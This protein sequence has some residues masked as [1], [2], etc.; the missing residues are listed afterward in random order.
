MRIMWRRSD[1]FSPSSQVPREWKVVKLWLRRMS[2][3]HE[4]MAPFPGGLER[5][6]NPGCAPLP[7]SPNW[8]VRLHGWIAFQSNVKLHAQRQQRPTWPQRGV[9]AQLGVCCHS[10]GECQCLHLPLLDRWRPQVLCNLLHG[11]LHDIGTL[12]YSTRNMRG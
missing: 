4:E 10:L 9:K 12:R 8:Q 2:P 1:S 6:R 5:G 7:L 3:V 11:R